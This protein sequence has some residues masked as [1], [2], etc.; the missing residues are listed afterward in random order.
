MKDS[1]GDHDDDNKDSLITITITHVKT[2]ETGGAHTVL[3][4]VIMGLAQV[5][6]T[7]GDTAVGINVLLALAADSAVLAGDF[8]SSDDRDGRIF[9]V[10]AVISI[11]VRFQFLE[12]T[13]VTVVSS[14][15]LATLVT[16]NREW[17][18]TEERKSKQKRPLSG[19]PYEDTW[20]HSHT[21]D[22]G[23]DTYILALQVPPL[24]Q[25]SSPLSP[26][27]E[28]QTEVDWY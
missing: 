23:C 17:K 13:A 28:G 4:V 24:T 25:N 5:G 18:D 7:V 26:S 22:K 9:V 14:R 8:T 16:V 20:I 19:E 27:E 2:N 6:N 21:R 1:D 12:F 3:K 15:A 10:L 11:I